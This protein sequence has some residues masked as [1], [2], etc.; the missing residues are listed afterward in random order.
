MNKQFVAVS[1][2]GGTN[3]TALL[4]AMWRIGFRPDIILFANT[5][6]ERP[7]TYDYV[8]MFSLWLQNKGFPP[9]HWV[10]TQNKLGQYYTLEQRCLANK[11]LP[12]LAYGYKACSEKHKQ[13]PQ[14]KFLRQWKPALDVWKKKGK[15]LK[16]IGYDAGETH[17]KSILSDD[18]YE[19]HYL[20]RIL[21]WDR[22]K[23]VEVIKEEGL[24]LPGKSSCFFCPAMK[25]KEILILKRTQPD[26][27]KRALEIENNAQQ[28]LKSVKGLGRSFAWADLIKQGKDFPD[29][30]DTYSDFSPY[31]GCYDG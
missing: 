22:K 19:Y 11:M 25:K 14:H 21:K 18:Y 1:Y 16:L 24:P 9:I 7:D 12:S 8:H 20:L 5:G 3:S 2:G 17:R 13:R 4:I 23:C 26:L 27:L 28:N 15:V 29:A 31:C 6:G 30:Y 10:M